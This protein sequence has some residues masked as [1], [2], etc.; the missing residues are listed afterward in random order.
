MAKQNLEPVSEED[1]Q[2]E[3]SQEPV[4]TEEQ[5][6][7][8]QKE[9][10]QKIAEKI[11]TIITDKRAIQNVIMVGHH[12]IDGLRKK[13]K[14]GKVK[15]KRIDDIFHPIKPLL[16]SIYS[17]FQDTPK[18]TYLCADYHA[19]QE[20][21]INIE[22]PSSSASGQEYMTITQYIV[23]TGGTELDDDLDVVNDNIPP[24]HK[25]TPTDGEP[26]TSYPAYIIKENKKTCGFLECR[27]HGPNVNFTF[28]DATPSD[29]DSEHVGG[30]SRKRKR[31]FVQRRGTMH[32]RRRASHQK[33][34]KQRRKTRKYKSK[35]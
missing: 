19:Y 20:G 11:S 8:L 22:I 21:I 25:E 23:G 5:I 10:Q 24:E 13:V 2:I 14:D 12:P 27:V 34:K 29:T 3:K 17:Q 35:T 28:V 1:I 30:K 16:H 6:Q 7:Q 9:Q 4:S 26:T 18:Y 15:I 33:T 32:K 31:R